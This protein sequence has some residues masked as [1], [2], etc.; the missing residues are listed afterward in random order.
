MLLTAL[1]NLIDARNEDDVVRT[2]ELASLVAGALG[3]YRD[4]I[5]WLCPSPR[6]SR[7]RSPHAT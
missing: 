1:L 2:F 4:F 6:G 7:G 5:L 3:V